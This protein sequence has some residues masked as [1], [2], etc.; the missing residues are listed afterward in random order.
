MSIHSFIKPGVFR[1]EMI[2]LMSE[3]FEAACKELHDS[4]QPQIVREVIADRIITATRQGELDPVRLRE[5]ALAGVPDTR[6]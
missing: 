4:G 5:A 2:A 1:P 3:A 6:D